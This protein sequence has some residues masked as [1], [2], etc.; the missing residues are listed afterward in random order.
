MT[1]PNMETDLAQRRWPW[2]D[3]LSNHSISSI[4]SEAEWFAE[5]RETAYYVA[6]LGR[7]LE[8]GSIIAES[9]VGEN[10]ISMDDDQQ[11]KSWSADRRRLHNEKVRQKGQREQ[12]TRDSE[13]LMLYMDLGRMD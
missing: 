2:G 3:V 12:I 6:I 8:N 13:V 7:S 9:T 5:H 10:P 4:H 11:G 1:M